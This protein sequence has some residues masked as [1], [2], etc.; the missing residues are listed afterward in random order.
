MSAQVRLDRLVGRRVRAANNRSIGRIQEFRA[1]RRDGGW[2]VIACAIGSAGL[3][4]R[5]DMRARLVI[6]LSW[7]RRGYLARWDQIDFSN[8]ESPRLL[9]AVDELDAL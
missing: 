6:G 5:L 3:W 7:R 8:P 2:Q 1:E 9:C 4:E